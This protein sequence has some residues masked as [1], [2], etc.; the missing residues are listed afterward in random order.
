MPLFDDTD[1]DTAGTADDPGPAIDPL[2]LPT[3]ERDYIISAKDGKG[4][5]FRVMCR[6][7]PELA[8]LVADVHASKKYPFRTQGDLMRYCVWAMTR[9]L[10]SGAGIKSVMA[11]M[12]LINAMCVDEE[13]QLQF[14]ENHR[15]IK[16]VVETYLE[17]G[18][19]D[20]ARAFLANL[21]N[22]LKQMPDGYWRERHETELLRRYRNLIDGHNAPP[23]RTSLFADESDPEP[24]GALTSA[25]AQTRSVLEAAL[26]TDESGLLEGDD[27][28]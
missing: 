1:P 12:D 26:D 19:P 6:V 13:Y 2:G 5:S 14:A 15:A 16:R 9:R 4:V 7:S 23:S 24:F 8:R 11:Q 3:R 20:Q 21:R 10:A 28:E 17:H 27:E 25:A 22:N 18:S